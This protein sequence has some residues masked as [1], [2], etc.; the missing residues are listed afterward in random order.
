MV[1]YEDNQACIKSILRKQ[2]SSKLRHIR[3][4]HHFIRDLYAHG[5]FTVRYISTDQQTADA[6]TKPLKSNL[7]ELH[8]KFMKVTMCPQDG[9]STCTNR[10]N[11]D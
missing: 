7:L 3:V 10:T 2:H 6:L 5:R 1:L 8:K 9:G 11:D 4:R